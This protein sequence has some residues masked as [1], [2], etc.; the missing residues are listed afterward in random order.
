MEPFSKF[1]EDVIHAF[2]DDFIVH[3]H[4]LFYKSVIFYDVGLFFQF[5]ETNIQGSIE[6]IN[7]IFSKPTNISE[8]IHERKLAHRLSLFLFYWG[9]KR[10][11]SQTEVNFKEPMRAIVITRPRLNA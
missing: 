9:A 8:R 4:K 10:L 7:F 3:L 2:L 1:S 11:P 6:C 5:I